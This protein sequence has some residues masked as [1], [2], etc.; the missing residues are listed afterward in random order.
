MVYLVWTEQGE[1]EQYSHDLRAI[2][3]DKEQAEVH[4][5]R[6]GGKVEEW[7]IL[8]ALPKAVTHYRWTDHIAQDGSLSPDEPRFGPHF[9]RRRDRW[10]S[11]NNEGMAVRG[12]LRD[13]NGKGDLYVEV[14]GCDRE[15]VKA[16]Y[17]RLVKE[18]RQRIRA[19]TPTPA[20]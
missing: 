6:L 7:D 9:G 16:E 13:W 14:E 12:E 4:A 20:A 1:Y 19:L 8:T 2:F 17:A 3:A 11:W 10:P 18:G 5:G 15:A